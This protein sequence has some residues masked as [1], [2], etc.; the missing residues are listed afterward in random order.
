MGG[1]HSGD[2]RIVRNYNGEISELD[3]RFK[4]LRLYIEDKER[5]I[6]SDEGIQKQQHRDICKRKQG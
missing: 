3:L 1:K 5:G 6:V 4:I 2:R